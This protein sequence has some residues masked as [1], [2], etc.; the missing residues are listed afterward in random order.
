MSRTHLTPLLLLLASCFGAARPLTA[1]HI[2]AIT[3]FSI[4][5]RLT[6]ATSLNQ[7]NQVGIGGT[8]LGHM[9]NHQ[10]KTYFLFGDTFSGDTPAIGGNW[11][12]NA[13]SWSVDTQPSDGIVFEDWLRTGSTAREV[14]RSGI[15][16]S[17]T[18]IPTGGVSIG[19]RIYAWYMAVN[20]WGPPGQWT[21][22]HAG[23]AYWQPGDT[24]F[25]VVPGFQFPSNSN[26]GMVA[27][28]FRPAAEGANDDNLY[29]WGTPP[30]RFGGVKLARVPAD[31]V[32]NM[33]SYRYFDGLATGEPL[34][35]A[36]EFDANHLVQSNVGEMSV[37]YNEAVGQWTM[38][39]FNELRAA[40]ELR[41]APEPWGPW[42]APLT[43]TT[44][45]QTPG[46]MY[47]PYMNPLYVE[48]G[49]QT[50]YFTM[51]LWDTYDVYLAKATFRIVPEPSTALL[52]FAGVTVSLWCRWRRR[53]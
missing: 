44:S 50:V 43:I 52:A 6:G 10:G 29:I 45:A 39:Y 36:S 9:V 5:S 7:T 32:A 16:G 17:I 46:G 19:N 26:F 28:S 12:H 25:T 24:G 41:Q 40:I 31:E 35:T 1:A 4:V 14:I 11:R 18:E 30:G 27:A 48:N 13:M 23:L 38:M 8:D 34:W 42:S 49:G 33:S 37:M 21:N 22:S 47:A 53:L 20:F 2:Q 51:S 15:G 3:S